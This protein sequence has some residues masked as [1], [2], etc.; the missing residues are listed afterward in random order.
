MALDFN[1]V[2]PVRFRGKECVPEITTELRM[3]LSQIKRYDKHDDEILAAAFP[4]D[5]A[6]VKD[7]LDNHITLFEKQMLHAYL[8]GGDSAVKPITEKL[9]DTMSEAMKK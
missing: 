9:K 6:Y 4:N 2:E 3:R 8:L 1:G 7:F 5:E